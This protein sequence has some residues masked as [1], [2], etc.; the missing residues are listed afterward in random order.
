MVSK[1]GH[2]HALRHTGLAPL[3]AGNEAALFGGC[4]A[5]LD[6]GEFWALLHWRSARDDKLLS[7]TVLSN[8][9]VGVAGRSP[10]AI[11]VADVVVAAEP[12]ASG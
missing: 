4:G 1:T 3:H 6:R 9:G 2:W 10:P 11:I 12:A 8:N 7:A 5:C